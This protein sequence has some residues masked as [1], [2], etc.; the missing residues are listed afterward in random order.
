MK[1][2]NITLKRITIS[3]SVIVKSI[4]LRIYTAIKNKIVLIQ[5]NVETAIKKA[6]FPKK[7]AMILDAYNS[8]ILKTVFE[9]ARNNLVIR[10]NAAPVSTKFVGTE[11]NLFELVSKI[12][13][14][15]LS[16]YRLLKDMDMDDS[17]YLDLATFDEI[18]LEELDYIMI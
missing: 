2:F 13:G 5:H 12:D 4:P 11:L 7:D 6:A 1:Q 9:K 17:S 18:T 15:H 3:T 8:G 16:K 10:S 14:C